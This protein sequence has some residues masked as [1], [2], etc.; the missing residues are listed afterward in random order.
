MQA[1]IPFEGGT[2]ATEVTRWIADDGTLHN[3]EALAERADFV[4]ALTQAI[5]HPNAARQIAEQIVTDYQAIRA[6]IKDRSQV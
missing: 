2:L 1:F 6:V 4:H 3:T 5:S